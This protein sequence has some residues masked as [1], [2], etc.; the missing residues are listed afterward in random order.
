M[1]DIVA[2]RK[3]VYGH[4]AEHLR[5]QE[6]DEVYA[7]LE[8]DVLG[9]GYTI[10]GKELTTTEVARYRKAVDTVIDRLDSQS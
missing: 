5:E 6:L 10:D 4:L 3:L 8:V 1:A 7:D 2:L 9:D